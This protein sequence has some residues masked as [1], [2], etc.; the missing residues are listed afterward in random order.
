MYFSKN[1]LTRA[2]L[3]TATLFYCK[4]ESPS[5]SLTW[6]RTGRRRYPRSLVYTPSLM[7]FTICWQKVLQF[8]CQQLP[9][10]IME[11]PLPSHCGAMQSVIL[12]SGSC[13]NT[14]I[15]IPESL[16]STEH[17]SLWISPFH[18]SCIQSVYSSINCSPWNTSLSSS[19][20]L[21][22]ASHCQ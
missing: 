9:Q 22:F 21:F 8:L 6:F 2:A 5:V 10:T 18:F 1:S 11:I 15:C 3:Y 14:Y 19:L 16:I 13:P 4:M 17:S 12:F 20:N 7:D